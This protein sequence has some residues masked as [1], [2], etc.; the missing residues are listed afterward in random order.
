MPY[1]SDC[2]QE[3]GIKGFWIIEIFSQWQ[4]FKREKIYIGLC[5]VYALSLKTDAY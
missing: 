3:K 5:I 1:S 2:K 4:Y